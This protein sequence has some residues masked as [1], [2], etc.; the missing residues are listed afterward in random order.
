MDVKSLRGIAVRADFSN[1]EL[2]L[3]DG[4]RVGDSSDES[5]VR[6]LTL[7]YSSRL[8]KDSVD[9]LRN[10]TYELSEATARH[11]RRLAWFTA[12]LFVLAAVQVFLVVRA[13][14]P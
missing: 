13:A 6:T 4:A 5:Y 1:D 9:G 7:I 12:A 10:T 2:E 11:G 14:A 3:L 8:L